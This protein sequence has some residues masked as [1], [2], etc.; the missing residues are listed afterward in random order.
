MLQLYHG[1]VYQ[2]EFDVRDVANYPFEPPKVKMLTKIWH[3]NVNADDG[4]LCCIVFCCVL[5]VV[6]VVCVLSV[7][8]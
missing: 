3:I 4:M 6:C 1:G 2:L 7:L 8:W 5:R